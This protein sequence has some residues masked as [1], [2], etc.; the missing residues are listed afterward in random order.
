MYFKVLSSSYAIL[1]VSMCHPGHA[2]VKETLYNFTQFFNAEKIGE[3]QVLLEDMTEY[4]NV[5]TGKR[6]IPLKLIQPSVIKHW[7]SQII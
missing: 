3:T 4:S 6:N 5:I 2:N 7:F 1:A